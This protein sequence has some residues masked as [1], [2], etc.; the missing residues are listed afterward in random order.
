[1]DGAQGLA[2]PS[3]SI[4]LHWRPACAA[5]GTCGQG[6]DGGDCTHAPCKH[7]GKSRT[8]KQQPVEQQQQQAHGHGGQQ[9]SD[10]QQRPPQQLQP[11]K[12][13][14]GRRQQRKSGWSSWSG[15][16]RPQPTS[17][18]GDTGSARGAQDR[19][20]HTG[21]R[22]RTGTGGL[23]IT[24]LWALVASSGVGVQLAAGRATHSIRLHGRFPVAAPNREELNDLIDYGHPILEHNPYTH[25]HP[26]VRR[27][28]LRASRWAQEVITPPF[29][30]PPVP[31]PP[32]P[33][34]PQPPLPPPESPSAALPPPSPPLLPLPPPPSP[35]LLAPLPPPPSPPPSPQ[36]PSPPPPPPLPLTQFL[37]TVSTGPSSTASCDVLKAAFDA[38]VNFGAGPRETSCEDVTQQIGATIPTFSLLAVYDSATAAAAGLAA[39]QSRMGAF[40]TLGSVSCGGVVL[41][42]RTVAN[43]FTC[44]A[45]PGGTGVEVPELCCSPP[46]PAPSPSRPPPQPPSPR[47]SPPS[48]YP[49][50]NPSSPSDPPPALSPPAQP[51]LLPPPPPQALPTSSTPSTPPQP[52]GTAAPSEGATSKSAAP[53]VVAAVVPAV[54]LV[55]IAVGVYAYRRR[56]LL[57]DRMLDLMGPHDA[58]AAASTPGGTPG[59]SPGDSP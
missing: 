26:V 11:H 45:G 5:Q 27:R 15:T 53:I 38:I 12:L 30:G 41:T 50:P 4:A 51:E 25:E 28:L 19:C 59:Y 24:L 40:V 36:P 37:V 22:W 44:G 9:H 23:V 52:F 33:V 42:A 29:Y 7:Q 10:Q 16:S 3:S 2:P 31:A 43:Y 1:M 13:R 35:L 21:A 55:G 57:E 46:P 58:P 32:P 20:L 39:F 49:A 48:P 34:V 8:R 17:A 6:Q 47:S 54:A 18:A 56:R 14:Q